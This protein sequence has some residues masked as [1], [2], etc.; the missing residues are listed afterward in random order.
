[1]NKSNSIR[2]ATLVAAVAATVAMAASAGVVAAPLNLP[3]PPLFLNSAVDPNL[4]VT[5]DDS[6]SMAWGYMPDTVNGDYC[7]P[8]YYWS[9]YN[10]IYYNPALRYTPPLKSDG[11]PFPDAT[12][13]AAWRDGYEGQPTT[14]VAMAGGTSTVDLKTR[15]FPTRVFNARAGTAAGTEVGYDTTCTGGRWTLPFATGTGIGT[16]GTRYSSAFYYQFTGTDPTDNA[17]ITNA[18]NFVAVDVGA[19]SAA[20][21]QNFANWYSYYRTRFLFARSATSRA[22]ARLDNNLRVAWQ[23]LNSQQFVAATEIRKYET[24]WRQAYFDWLYRTPASGNTPTRAS[25]IRAGNLFTRTAANATNPYYDVT[26]ARE[27]TCRQNFHILVTDGFWNENN[28]AYSGYNDTTSRALPDGLHAYT[29][30]SDPESRIYWNKAASPANGCAGPAPCNPTLSDITF[31]YWARD[32]RTD[33]TDNVPPYFPD[34]STGIANG[35]GV[36]TPI[37]SITNPAAIK[38]IYFNPANDPATWQH[39][40]QFIVGLGVAGTLGFPN[41]YDALRQGTIQWPGARNNN[42][43][44]VDDTWHAA[45]NSRGQYFSAGD[46]QALV[47]SLNDLLSSVLVRRGTAS[48]ATVTSGIIQASTLAFRTGFDSGDWTGQ[49]TAWDVS[50]NGRLLTQQWEAGARLLGRDPN[51]RHIITSSSVTGTGVPFRW[52]DLPSDYRDSLDDNPETVLLD[53]DDAGEKRL[54]F[55]RGDR[56]LELDQPG[57][58][59]RIRAGLLGAVINSGAVVVAAPAAGYTDEFPAGSPEATAI[60]SDATKSYARFRADLKNRRRI[61]YVGANDGMLHAF[62]AGTGVSS[63][64][65]SGNPIVDA[66]TGDELW[67]YVPREVAPTLSALT[68]PNYEFSPYVDNS[69]VV[70]DVFFGGRWRT[71]L[72]GSLRRG[73]QGLFALDITNPNVTEADAASLV[74]WE[75]SDDHPSLTE[76]RRLGYTFGRPNIARLANDKWVVVIPGGYNNEVA[77]GSQGDGSSSLFVLDIV[78]GSLIREF[79]LPTSRGL[80]TPTMGDYDDDFIDEFAVAGDLNGDVWRFD[81]SNANPNS[82]VVDKL[83]QA[84]TAGTQPITSAPRLFPDTKTGGLIV[85]VGTGKYLEPN[86]R[87]NVGVPTQSMYGIREK[88]AGSASYPILRSS[89]TAQ[90]LTKTVSGTTNFYSLSNNAVPLSSNG[91]YFNFLELGERDVTSAGALFTLGVAIVSSVIPN[92]DDP[93]NPGLRGNVYL[94]D[95]SSGT[96]P[97]LGALFDT[98]GDGTV[99]AADNGNYVGKSVD[100]TVAEGSPAV[101]VGAGGGV[102]TLV[103]FPDIQVPQTVWRRRSWREITPQ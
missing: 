96:G 91:W 8:R 38:E 61:V 53:D 90:T 37:G 75:F 10:R 81:M 73:G 18:A 28:P 16:V 30:G 43:L 40:V 25:T 72:V 13:T 77:D 3:K 49:V 87:S 103:D 74:Q 11:S 51:L 45:I 79:N 26:L 23:N 47:E 32:L 64:D 9:G 98:N 7:T 54:E 35:T 31:N 44:A 70:R 14:T 100:S 46:P 33:L 99:S 5:F 57:G 85:V 71:I 19:Q 76:A 48:A 56:S 42:Q 21:Q 39:V 52:N 59:F 102:G 17:Q 27:L 97:N 94:L 22:F 20:E 67:A 58:I 50:A 24:T 36:V 1:M 83:Y 82:W 80:A 89:L 15:Y 69:P 101:L 60:S 66:G 63:F 12:F 62:D 4:A 55:I 86:D 68:N 92:G 41:D 2:K 34:K 93:C 65:A 78:D 84:P 29:V 88:G 95:A 6:G